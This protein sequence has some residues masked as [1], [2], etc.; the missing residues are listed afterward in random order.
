MH[1]YIY[2]D[3]PTTYSKVRRKT[4]LPAK[5]CAYTRRNLK[6]V[7]LKYLTTAMKKDKNIVKKR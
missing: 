5:D 4:T 1:T 3:K 7:G 2:F 6:V